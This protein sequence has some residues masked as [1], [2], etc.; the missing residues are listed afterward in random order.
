MASSV[1]RWAASAKY[2]SRRQT[3]AQ[4]AFNVTDACCPEPLL[5][6]VGAEAY[7]VAETVVWDASGAGLGKQPCVGYSQQPPGGL[8]VYE[9]REWGTLIMDATSA[10]PRK[11]RHG[12][13]AHGVPA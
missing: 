8:G 12:A 9:R 6:I 10:A 1:P 2:S 13:F 3:S 5:E 4:S 11:Y 7:V